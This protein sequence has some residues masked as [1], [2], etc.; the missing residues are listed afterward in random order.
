[1]ADANSDRLGEMQPARFLFAT[2]SALSPLEV[3]WRLGT[4]KATFKSAAYT[5]AVGDRVFCY[6]ED[7]QLLVI[8][9][10]G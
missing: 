2:V 6:L 3:T 8:C 10:T 5:P 9:A 4:R 1:M 7:G